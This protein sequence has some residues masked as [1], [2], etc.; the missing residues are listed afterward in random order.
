MHSRRTFFGASALAL[1]AVQAQT[2]TSAATGA[3]YDFAAIEERLNRPFRHR[4]AFGAYRLAD[5]AVAAFMLNAL[6]AYE[7]DYG[8]GSGTLHAL[9]IFYGTATAMLLDDTA[10]RTYQLAAVQQHR[11]DPAKR[12]ATSGG[13]PYAAA[14]SPLDRAAA[15]GDLHG[16]YHD[17]SLAAL[18]LRQASFFACDNS[19]RGL[20]TDIAVTYAISDAPVQVVH[21]DLRAHLIPGVLLVPAGVAAVNEAQEKKFTFFSSPV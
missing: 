6:N 14:T 3:P 20:A 4:Q 2:T 18:A 16:L 17:V 12:L 9:A 8:E 21:A 10:W 7:F 11:G 5:G 19:L 1:A 13:N 15:R